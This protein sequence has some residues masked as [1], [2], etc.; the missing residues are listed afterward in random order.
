MTSDVPLTTLSTRR[1]GTPCHIFD[2]PYD[3]YIEIFSHV[4]WKTHAVCMDVCTFW[5]QILITPHARAKRFSIDSDPR[6]HQIFKSVF[7]RH[8]SILQI[9]HRN[10]EIVSARF[11]KSMDEYDDSHYGNEDRLLWGLELWKPRH[12]ILDDYLF[13]QGD[14]DEIAREPIEFY[15]LAITGIKLIVQ[16]E[17]K[18]FNISVSMAR[19]MLENTPKLRE[20]TLRGC[21]RLLA[22]YVPRIQLFPEGTISDME[23]LPNGVDDLS[24]L[25]IRMRIADSI[26]H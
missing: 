4:S 2:L 9:T 5:R 1:A 11:K 23:L 7:L 10:G 22:N 3:V 13:S 21:I 19:W 17:R 15:Q 26:Q 6:V 25:T 14:I 8:T 18:S 16:R 24:L 20:I 12:P